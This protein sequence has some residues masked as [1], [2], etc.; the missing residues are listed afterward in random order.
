MRFLSIFLLFILCVSL[1]GCGDGMFRVS[2]TVT[3]PDNAPLTVGAVIFANDSYT[4]K[5]ALDSRGGYSIKVPPGQ[6]KVSIGF[7]SIRDESFV[8]PP[9]NPDAVRHIELVHPSYASLDETP[10]VCDIVRSGTHNFTVERPET[11]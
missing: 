1:T 10:L 5:S 7:A 11:P 2:G 6:Y 4:N 3:F 9:D 8:P